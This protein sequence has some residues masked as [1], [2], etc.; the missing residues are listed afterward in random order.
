[1]EKAP[2]ISPCGT[3]TEWNERWKISAE[4]LGFAPASSDEEKPRL[5]HRLIMTWPRNAVA[6]KMI[7]KMGAMGL[8]VH[9]CLV[10]LACGF[11]PWASLPMIAVRRDIDR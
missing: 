4:N 11:V 5:K 8:G 3:K 6:T 2:P 9:D 10:D 1:M 7:V